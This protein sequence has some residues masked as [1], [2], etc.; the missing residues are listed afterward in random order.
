M[1][2]VS[3]FVRLSLDYLFDFSCCCSCRLSD[4]KEIDQQSSPCPFAFYMSSP[5]H[6]L[7]MAL[8]DPFLGDFFLCSCTCSILGQSS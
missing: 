3:S 4:A 6:I 8:Y 1:K 7:S 5:T 2:E